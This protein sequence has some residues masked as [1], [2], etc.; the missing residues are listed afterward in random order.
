VEGWGS[1]LILVERSSRGVVEEREN[2]I[3]VFIRRNEESE[4]HLKCKKQNTQ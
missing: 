4:C 1:P 3:G 2:G